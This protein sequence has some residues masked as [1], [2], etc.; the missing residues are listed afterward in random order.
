MS[1]IIMDQRQ[2]IYTEVYF[3]LHENAAFPNNKELIY[4][5]VVFFFKKEIWTSCSKKTT[6]QWKLFYQG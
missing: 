6:D 5:S 1:V 2:S 3:L 4:L